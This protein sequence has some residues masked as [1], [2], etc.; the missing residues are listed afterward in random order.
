MISIPWYVSALFAPLYAPEL[1][2]LA[3]MVLVAIGVLLSGWRL[4]G[5]S[6]FS[7]AGLLVGLIFLGTIYV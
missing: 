5:L 2:V 3:V 7:L 4:I 6:C 1:T